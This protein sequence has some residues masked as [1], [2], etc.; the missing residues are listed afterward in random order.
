MTT[1]FEAMDWEAQG[2]Y[3]PPPEGVSTV[4]ELVW[5]GSYRQSERIRPAVVRLFA[6]ANTFLS[7]Q[8]VSSRSTTSVSCPI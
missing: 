8:R 3:D 7:S 5:G 6:Y 1:D 4:L 2:P